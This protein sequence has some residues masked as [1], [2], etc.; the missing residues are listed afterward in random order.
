M[1][2]QELHP[3]QLPLSSITGS[4][5]KISGSTPY[6][7]LA[8]DQ[9]YAFNWTNQHNFGT[10]LILDSANSQ[11]R[12]SNFIGGLSGFRIDALTGNS[13]LNNIVARGEIRTSVLAYDEQ[14]VR[15]GTDI[16]A[17]SAGVL[18]S[19][20]IVPTT[21]SFTISVKD[22]PS[23]H[24]SLFSIGDLLRM[25][26]R[27]R[28]VYMQTTAIV[29]KTSYY[30]YD[31]VLLSG[32][33][34]NFY[35][36]DGVID[37]G[38]INQGF[39]Y[40]SA[41]DT[42]GPMI[43]V[44]QVADTI[45]PYANYL[46][47]ELGDILICEDGSRLI[48]DG[49][50]SCSVNYQELFRAGNLSGIGSIVVDTP[51]IFIG[52]SSNYLKYT[53]LDGFKIVAD[54]SSITNI[55]GGNISANSL[56]VISANTGHLNISGCLITGAYP[57]SR[58]E[59]TPLEISGYSSGSVKEFYLS[60]QDGKA[61][62]GYFTIDSSGISVDATS[63]VYSNDRSFHF[64]SGST[65]FGGLYGYTFNEGNCI[66]LAS[67]PS[68]GGSNTNAYCRVEAAAGNGKSGSLILM[69]TGNT[70]T[71][72]GIN[73]YAVNQNSSNSIMM[74]GGGVNITSDGTPTAT[75]EGQLYVSGSVGFNGAI[76]RGKY[77][78]TAASDPTTTMN[79]A[80]SIRTLLINCGLAE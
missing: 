75:K 64:N 72:V 9:G 23:I 28:D 18:Y 68:T 24:A 77:L 5:L 7:L 48:R 17:V 56:S 78:L 32:G 25:K 62:A 51:G 41:D 43:S 11:I 71:S 63:I 4:G 66:R 27:L 12:S 14:L 40:L 33:L 13:E 10:N 30:D 47:D 37:Y 49:T 39:L 67:D 52:D 36:G 2:S 79:L 21:G 31:V 3:R 80:N 50:S 58:I 6:W 53:K 57:N 60:S 69:A 26:A 45:F 34:A 73:L 76:P 8:V 55:Q 70:I 22:P 16:I 38:Q 35:A 59:I 61:K 29:D 74:Y 54:G 44:R 42:Y 19:D 15:A 20:V 65:P 1:A 46:L